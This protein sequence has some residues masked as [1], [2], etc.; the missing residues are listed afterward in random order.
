MGEEAN[1]K[2][3]S[4]KK[5]KSKEK[6]E[7]RSGEETNGSKNERT[8]EGKDK[9]TVVTGRVAYRKKYI[10]SKQVDQYSERHLKEILGT[11]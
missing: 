4:K 8:E 11:I 7:G 3:K 2:K 5:R 6:A 1:D 9:K 10:K